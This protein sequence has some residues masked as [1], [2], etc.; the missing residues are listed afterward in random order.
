MIE[1]Y[2]LLAIAIAWIFLC[3]IFAVLVLINHLQGVVDSSV[4]IS[5]FVFEARGMHAHFDAKKLEW[6]INA[7]FL[8]H[9]I[10]RGD[11]ISINHT[12]DRKPS[13]AL[14]GGPNVTKVRTMV[15]VRDNGALNVEEKLIEY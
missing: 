8:E 2:F 1:V 7:A 11:I 12:E 3:T 9:G 10:K 4:Q 5:I 15:I 14:T 6:A 13:A